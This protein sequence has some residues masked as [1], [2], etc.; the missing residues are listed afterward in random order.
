MVLLH[1]NL[2]YGFMLYRLNSHTESCHMGV[3]GVGA[4]L[5]D[6]S[7]SQARGQSSKYQSVQFRLSFCSYMRNLCSKLKM[8]FMRF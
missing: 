5:V 1:G 7:Q 6:V 4:R 2:L 3:E 8:L